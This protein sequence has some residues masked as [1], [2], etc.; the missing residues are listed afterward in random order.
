MHGFLS[1]VRLVTTF[2]SHAAIVVFSFDFRFACPDFDP[3]DSTPPFQFLL[4]LLILL[5]VFSVCLCPISSISI[6]VFH[7]NCCLRSFLFFR[8]WLLLAIFGFW[9]HAICRITFFWKGVSLSYH[10]NLL[11]TF[12]SGFHYLNLLVVKVDFS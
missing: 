7:E 10:L 6:N 4:L 5:G 3:F 12:V 2:N 1:S 9:F 8:R 11:C